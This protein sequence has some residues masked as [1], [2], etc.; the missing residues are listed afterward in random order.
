MSQLYSLL[1][2]Y[3]S[4]LGSLLLA[5]LCSVISP[6]HLSITALPAPRMSLILLFQP[7]GGCIESALCSPGGT[8]Y[9][10]RGKSKMPQV[11]VAFSSPALATENWWLAHSTSPVAILKSSDTHVSTLLLLCILKFRDRKS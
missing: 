6:S 4:N 9:I 3:K 5:V 7:L 10:V 8:S 2:Y 1:P 11:P